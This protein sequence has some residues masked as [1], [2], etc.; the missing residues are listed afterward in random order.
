MAY[1]ISF[2]TITCLVF[3]IDTEHSIDSNMHAWQPTLG[4]MAVDRWQLQ[5]KKT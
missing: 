1:V 4:R 3:L 5:K 2:I